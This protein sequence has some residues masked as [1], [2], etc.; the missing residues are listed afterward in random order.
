MTEWI[1]RSAQLPKERG[2]Y[3]VYDPDYPEPVRVCTFGTSK[4]FDNGR[5]SIRRK[6][7]RSGITH[8]MPLPAPPRATSGE[9]DS[10]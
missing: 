6:S 5:D 10:L 8:W 4:G 3:L 9:G 1:E 7:G 2:A